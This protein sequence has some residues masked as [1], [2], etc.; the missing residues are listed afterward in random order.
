MA[1]RPNIPERV[2]IEV[3]TEAAGRCQFRGCNKPLWFNGLTLNKKNFGKMAHI[4]GASKGGPRGNDQSDELAKDP[5]NIMLLCGECHDE[6]DDGIL[7]KLY[8]V[9]ELRNMKKEH[10]ERVRMLLSL[11]SKKTRPL[12]LKT[13]VGWQQSVFGERSIKNAILPDYPD[14]A[15]SEWYNIEINSFDRTQD[16]EWEVAKSVI[17]REI[18]FVNRACA[19]GD[20]SHLSVF[21]LAPMPLLMYLGRLLGDKIPA[22]VFEPRRTDN[23]DERWKWEEE[24]GN[25][26]QYKSSIIKNGDGIDVLLLLALSD[27]LG[28]DKYEKVPL[29]SPHIYQLTID[30]PVQGFLIKKSDKAT[31]IQACRALL[32]LIQKEVGSDCRIHILPAIPAS[33]AVEFGRLI[34]PTKDPEISVFE[35]MNKEI[36]KLVLKL[37]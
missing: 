35:F 13:Q 16:S 11:P 1:N 4:I 20:I 26:I 21:A 3:W 29:V 25:S 30:T 6:I 9:D 2:R 27:F 31:F 36:P 15:G 22:Q 12:I 23:Q 37:S 14:K 8:S 28:K 7:Q 32:N 24:D 17:E 34:Q 5:G 19:A 33:L 10:S 18:E